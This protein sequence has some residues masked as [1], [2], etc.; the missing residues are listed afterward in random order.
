LAIDS[1]GWIAVVLTQ[2]FYL[3]NVLRILRTR[4]VA[5]YSLFGWMLLTGGL[6]CYLIYFVAQ[7]DPVGIVANLCGIAGAGITTL[8][9]WRWRAPLPE[10]LALSPQPSQGNP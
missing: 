8:C 6:G 4:N 9:I 1:I 3:P 10:H 5:G 7:G 2:V